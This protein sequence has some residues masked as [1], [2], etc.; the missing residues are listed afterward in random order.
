MKKGIILSLHSVI[1]YKNYEDAEQPKSQ[2][3]RYRPSAQEQKLVQ[4]NKAMI[5]WVRFGKGII[6]KSGNYT[7][8]APNFK[9]MLQISVTTVL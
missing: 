7:Y 2:N 1:F 8:D 3:I 4:T 6:L 9:T 5:S